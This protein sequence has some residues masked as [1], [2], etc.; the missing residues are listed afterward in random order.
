MAERFVDLMDRTFGATEREMTYRF[1]RSRR[2]IR[3]T[4]GIGI[5]W[6]SIL[7]WSILEEVG[8]RA[9]MKLDGLIYQGLWQSGAPAGVAPGGAPHRFSVHRLP[10]Q[11]PYG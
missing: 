3:Q 1:I 10:K 6:V 7:A 2:D 11:I 5:G 9:R 8:W 4:E